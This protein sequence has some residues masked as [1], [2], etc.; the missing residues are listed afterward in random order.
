MKSLD[1]NCPLLFV[2]ITCVAVA[3]CAVAPR[4]PSVYACSDGTDTMGPPH[5]Q[6]A[7]YQAV[8]DRA[9]KAGVPGMTLLVRDAEGT[10]IG[11]GGMAD[12]ATGTPMG[13]CQI[14]NTAS[15]TKTFLAATALKLVEEGRMHLDDP[16]RGYLP[17]GAADGLDGAD[18]ATVRELMNHTSG[19]RNYNDSLDF[20][21]DV[22]NAP[23]SRV[24]P[25]SFL[26]YARGKSAYF[27]PGTGH[28]YSNSDTILLAMVIDAVSGEHHTRALADRVLSPLSLHRTSYDW[29]LL[30]PPGLARGYAEWQGDER[31]VDA[32]DFFF[33]EQYDGPAGGLNSTVT[34][35]A[36]FVDALLRKKTLVGAAS[37]AA[38][39]EWVEP[40][41]GFHPGYDKYGL[42]LEYLKGDLGYAIGHTGDKL[43]Y[44]GFML[45]FPDPDVTVVAL[46]NVGGD[47]PRFGAITHDLV[48]YLMNLPFQGR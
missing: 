10:W 3:G 46:L 6:S 40:P 21:T 16:I 20:L 2:T 37:L 38:M 32:T 24:P 7:R 26:D 12:L 15:I 22:I 17:K 41:S 23:S 35:L 25:Y 43:G 27:A 19:I 5:S 44:Q 8:I 47:S 30:Q 4:D 1:R 36:T 45:Y 48:G 9:I 13:T 11:A 42:G 28:R 39:E 33:A 34:D 18:T 14:F 31:L 29:K